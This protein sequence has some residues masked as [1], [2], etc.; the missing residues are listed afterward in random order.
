[1][2]QPP[3]AYDQLLSCDVVMKGGITSGVV[4]P[5]AITELAKR[6][7]FRN[8]GGT[9]AGAIAAAAAGAAEYARRHA[10]AGTGF[11]EVETLPVELGK[12]AGVVPGSRLLSLF[13]PQPGTAPIFSIIMAGLEKKSR[14]LSAAVTQFAGSAAL[15][16]SPGVLLIVA[17][18]LWGVGLARGLAIVAGLLLAAIGAAA[19]VALSLTRTALRELPKNAFGLC[20]GAS[21]RGYGDLPALTPWLTDLLDRIAGIEPAADGRRKPLTFGDLWGTDDQHADH[22]IELKFVTTNLTH[23]RPHQLPYD[24]TRLFF[25][26]DELR[27]YFPDH[28]VRWMAD[29]PRARSDAED[30]EAPPAELPRKY[31][32][33]PDA[34]N[35]PVVVAARLSLSFPFLISAV[36]LYAIDYTRVKEEDRVPERCWFSDGGLCSNFPVLFFDRPLPEWPTFAINLRD[37]HPDYPLDLEH[38]ENNSFV[39]LDNRGGIGPWWT[40]F[41]QGDGVKRLSG[42]AGAMVFA[43]KDWH[44]NVQLQVPGYRDRVVHVSLSEDEGG[45]N[46]NMPETLI[47]RLGDRGRFAAARLGKRFSPEGDGSPITW[48]NH[49]WIR[50][51]S[52]LA[53]VEDALREMRETLDVATPAG[54]SYRELIERAVPPSYRWASPAQREACLGWLDRLLGDDFLAQTALTF[55]EKAP[56]PRPEL[57][58]VPRF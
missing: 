49:R 27:R 56:H 19:C 31:L 8:I 54:T 32:P 25:D 40:R 51:R 47:T 34:A 7:R 57:R 10:T 38:E 17:A 36:P 39:V 29:H 53:L 24:I 26:P 37:L 48:D 46:L 45:L 20:S 41:D 9:S 21:A 22:E 13:Q 58:I 44:D 50:F 52:T 33:M 14:A 3:P 23:G 6:Y 28:V 2:G 30:D 18:A 12:D 11:G 4:Y 55:E 35:L 16:M 42:F 1:M 43:A 15:G 5:R